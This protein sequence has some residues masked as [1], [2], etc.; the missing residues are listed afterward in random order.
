MDT[1][2]QRFIFS[3]WQ[4]TRATYEARDEAQ[5]WHRSFRESVLPVLEDN[6]LQQQRVWQGKQRNERSTIVSAYASRPQDIP[7]VICTLF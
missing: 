6:D 5:D 7:P 3:S 2:I 4:T 1:A